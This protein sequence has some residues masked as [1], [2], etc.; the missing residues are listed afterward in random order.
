MEYV[1]T[2]NEIIEDIFNHSMNYNY[3]N[4]TDS[5]DDVIY[6]RYELCFME[7]KDLIKIFKEYCS[8][9]DYTVIVTK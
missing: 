1:I 9:N 4:L 8:L 7:N 2:R 3:N 5:Y 6:T